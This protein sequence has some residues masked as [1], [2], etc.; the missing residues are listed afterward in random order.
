MEERNRAREEAKARLV[1][2]V[3][4][5]EQ[6]HPEKSFGCEGCRF[7]VRSLGASAPFSNLYTWD[8][9]QER[10]DH[11]NVYMGYVDGHKY[12]RDLGKI[13]TACLMRCQRCN[14]PSFIQNLA[15]YGYCVECNKDLLKELAQ[16][17]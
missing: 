15:V 1:T 10:F 6:P 9:F 16:P 13:C 8:Q 7:Y 17:T 5:Q 4:L 12:N 11:K 14:V 3:P 2:W